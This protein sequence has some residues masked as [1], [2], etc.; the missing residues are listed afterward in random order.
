[1]A[2]KGS[3]DLLIPFKY[4]LS[5]FRFNKP[6][7]TKCSLKQKSPRLP[8]LFQWRPSEQFHTPTFPTSWEGNQ[9]YLKISASLI[10]G[11]HHYGS[12]WGVGGSILE[13]AQGSISKCSPPESFLPQAPAA[14]SGHSHSPTVK[15]LCTPSVDC[16]AAPKLKPKQ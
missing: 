1:M 3:R 7:I 10:S 9:R 5:R 13:K 14:S 15:C 16:W 12:F 2:P 6:H 11:C 8:L 4:L